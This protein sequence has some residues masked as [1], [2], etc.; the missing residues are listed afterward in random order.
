MKLLHLVFVVGVR[1]S[2]EALVSGLWH[3]VDVVTLVVASD[4]SGQLH[5]FSHHGDSVGVDGTEVGVFEEASEIGF[6]GFLESDQG[7]GLESEFIVDTRSERSHDSVEWSSWQQH[8]GRLLISLDF[9][10]SDG[11][12]S[13]PDLFLLLLALTL[14]SSFGGSSFLV[15]LLALGVNDG[16]GRRFLSF[17]DLGS[18]VLCLWHLKKVKVSCK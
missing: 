6:S 2:I 16:F 4:S 15:D 8:I 7:L 18:S 1:Q 13:E 11:A 14:H 9:S 10:E 3:G 17:A 5:V 12:W